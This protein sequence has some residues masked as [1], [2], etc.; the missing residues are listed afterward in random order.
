MSYNDLILEVYNINSFNTAYTSQQNRIIT[1]LQQLNNIWYFNVKCVIHE[2]PIEH[3]QM[4][5]VSNVST[6]NTS[7]HEKLQTSMY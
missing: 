4:S 7:V 1:A 6:Y 2:H 3:Q 5:T